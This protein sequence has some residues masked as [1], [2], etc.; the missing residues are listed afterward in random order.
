MAERVPL[1][2]I[3]HARSGDKGNRLNISVI[4]YRP[5]DYSLIVDQ[6]SEAR[7]RA[8]FAHRGCG[9]V[10]RYELPRIG[11]LN[12]VIDDVLEG[13]V[14]G[15]LNLDGHGKSLSFLLLTLPVD[16]PESRVAGAAD[17]PR[18]AP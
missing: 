9:R 4:A 2:R 17:Q 7:V 6:V 14:N 8:L 5:E 16:A 3:A 13:G 1:H 12:F 15:A 10:R 18:L 11:A